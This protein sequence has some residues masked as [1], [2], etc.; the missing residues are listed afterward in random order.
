MFRVI[1]RQFCNK[2][3]MIKINSVEELSTYLKHM[4]KAENDRFW[5]EM[6]QYVERSS[7]Y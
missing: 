3:F 5:H 4:P 1:S 2:T 6:R 7:P